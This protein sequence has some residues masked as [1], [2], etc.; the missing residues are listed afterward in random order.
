MSKDCTEEKV[1]RVMKCF[2]CGEEGHKSDECEK[3]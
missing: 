3:P 1:E 2:N